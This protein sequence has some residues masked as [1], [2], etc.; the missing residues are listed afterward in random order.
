[1]QKEGL[2]AVAQMVRES[3][4]RSGGEMD[5][6]DGVDVLAPCVLVLG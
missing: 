1:M 5:W 6:M 3:L 4:F 2:G